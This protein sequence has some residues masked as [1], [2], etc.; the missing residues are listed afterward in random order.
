MKAY[1]CLVFNFIFSLCAT[2]QINIA[3]QPTVSNIT[4]SGFTVIWA[5]DDTGSTSLKYGFTPSFELGVLTGPGGVTNH[6]VTLSG[7][8]A[9][10]VYYVQG[11]STSGIYTTYSDTKIFMTASNSSGIIKCYFVKTV[12]TSASVPA[13]NYAK[14]LLNTVDDTLAA[15]INRAQSTLDIAIY[16][17]DNSAP[18]TTI[19]N[20]LN[21][22]YSRGV[23]I[24]LIYE[25]SNSNT[26]LALLNSGIVT[27]GDLNFALMHNKF[28]V[29]DVN[30]ANA[31]QP[32]VWTGSTNWTTDQ[33]SIDANNVIVIQDQ[34]L[35]IAYTM[36][37][38]EM[39]G[40]SSAN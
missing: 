3:T 35:A 36:E 14:Q 5:T 23:R 31:N 24:R 1:Y 9:S 22:A 19:I 17:L 27:F 2:A 30:S 37:F 26:G 4:T 11:Y 7:A 18:A 40:G 32:V 34:S 21:S 38:E 39:W 16:N 33:L 12:D 20:A 15:Y 10:K 13:G 29:I 6:V 25:S 28:A 8:S